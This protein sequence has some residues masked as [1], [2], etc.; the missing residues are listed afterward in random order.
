MRIW[1]C[2][3][4]C[5]GSIGRWRGAL[6]TAFASGPDCRLGGPG[7]GLGRGSRGKGL[8]VKAEH[9]QC[10]GCDQILD[11]GTQRHGI[12]FRRASPKVP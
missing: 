2:W 4:L 10:G 9:G 7:Y 12:H 6:P 3:V 8:G 11:D 1:Q 5:A